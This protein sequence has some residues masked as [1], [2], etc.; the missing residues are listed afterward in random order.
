[1]N[2]KNKYLCFNWTNLQPLHKTE[3]RIKTNKLELHY[4]FNNI[5]NVNRFNK[6]NKQ[7]LGYQT[8]NE[9]LR[10]LRIELRYGKN[11]PDNYNSNE[12]Y[13]IGNPQPSL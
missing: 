13:E 4:Y 9:S 11:A 5:I 12:L 2:E 6:K 3:N 10:W 8:V 7:F 1:M